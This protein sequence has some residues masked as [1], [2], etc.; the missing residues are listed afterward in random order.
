MEGGRLNGKMSPFVLAC[1]AYATCLDTRF[2]VLGDF[3]KVTFW[4]TEAPFICFTLICHRNLPFPYLLLEINLFP[5]YKLM[6]K[7]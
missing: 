6:R 7:L 3:Q 5:L 1:W 2:Q 4:K